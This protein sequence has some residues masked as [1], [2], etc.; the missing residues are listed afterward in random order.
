MHTRRGDGG[1][2]AIFDP[3]TNSEDEMIVCAGIKRHYAC[4]YLRAYNEDFIIADFE[5]LIREG[6]IRFAA[7]NTFEGN[8]SEALR[9]SQISKQNVDQPS[10]R[11]KGSFQCG[12]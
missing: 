9:Q 3:I 12:F 1:G 6:H 2:M 7:R 5:W 11:Y 10:D 4:A 8:F